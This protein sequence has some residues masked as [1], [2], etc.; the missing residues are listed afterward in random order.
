MRLIFVKFTLNELVFRETNK[1]LCESNDD[2]RAALEVQ[3]LSF[4]LFRCCCFC[5]LF[6]F[7]SSF[8]YFPLLL[9]VGDKF[10]FSL[11]IV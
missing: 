6:C 3:K 10:T 11:H 7:V 8:L 4:L 1:R 5:C 2:L 9:S